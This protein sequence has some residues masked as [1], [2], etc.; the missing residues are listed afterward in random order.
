MFKTIKNKAGRY[1][2]IKTTKDYKAFAGVVNYLSMFCLN[3][4]KLLKPIYDLTG[5]G[6]SFIWSKLHQETF[7]EIKSSLLKPPVLHL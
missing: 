4:Q 6:R 5:K 7:E 1:T 2:K 3:L